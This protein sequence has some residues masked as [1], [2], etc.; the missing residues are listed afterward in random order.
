MEEVAKHNK[1]DDAWIV[2]E[3]K[4]YDVTTFVP[5]HPGGDIIAYVPL[6]PSPY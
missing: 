3:D 6:S 4:V 1:R 5:E 2:I